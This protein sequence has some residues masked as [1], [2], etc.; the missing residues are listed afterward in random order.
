MLLFW[1]CISV[2]LT[3]VSATSLTHIV[4][5]TKR[6]LHRTL[7]LVAFHWVRVRVYIKLK[8]DVNHV[9]GKAL[10]Y[11]R[12]SSQPINHILVQLSGTAV[13]V[14]TVKKRLLYFL[15]RVFVAEELSREIVACRLANLF[16]KDNAG[17]YFLFTDYTK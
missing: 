17:E 14:Y 8:E 11:P 3:A 7:A 6:F 4:H 9:V 13:R 12:A 15:R 5:E 2:E 1:L 16:P 10:M